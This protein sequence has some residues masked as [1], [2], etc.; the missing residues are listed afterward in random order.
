MDT[1]F[2]PERKS[3]NQNQV[4][5]RFAVKDTGT[6]RPATKQRGEQGARRILLWFGLGFIFIFIIALFIVALSSG[7]NN[8]LSAFGV[9]TDI[10][11]V[12]S[13]VSNVVFGVIFVCAIIALVIGGVFALSGLGGA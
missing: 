5:D 12:L 10:K 3:N 11:A 8:L 2:P 6:R 13:R 9:D 7:N 1:D 4:A